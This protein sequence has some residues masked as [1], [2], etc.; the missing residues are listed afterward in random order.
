MKTANS[1]PKIFPLIWLIAAMF[2]LIS[3]GSNAQAASTTPAETSYFSLSSGEYVILAKVLTVNIKIESRFVTDYTYRVHIICECR[4]QIPAETD[5]TVIGQNT[6]YQ[7]WAL[8]VPIMTQGTYF[9][10]NVNKT[11]IPNVFLCQLY[12]GFD[13]WLPIGVPIPSPVNK[14]DLT[15]FQTALLELGKLWNSG[16]PLT[17]TQVIKLKQSNNYYLWAL[18]TWAFAK[19]ALS[20]D[21]NLMTY[22]LG[23][24]DSPDSPTPWPL[25][26]PRQAFWIVYCLN[27]IVPTAVRPSNDELSYAM[28]CYLRRLATPRQPGYEP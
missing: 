8:F 9:V 21:V 4:N 2:A 28:K 10:M 16:K 6:S 7:S 20:Q 27:N 17:E 23:Q 5:I 19:I 18:G 14:D 1:F 26:S 15:S 11:S 13:E 3:A 12:K 22:E 24:Y 25:L